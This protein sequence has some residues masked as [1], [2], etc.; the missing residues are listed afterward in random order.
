MDSAEVKPIA[1][2]CTFFGNRRVATTT[3]QG[4]I[5]PVKK[6]INDT[7]KA[8]RRKPGTSQKTSSRNMEMRRYIAIDKLSPS[9]GDTNPNTNLPTVMPSQKPVSAIPEANA[10]PWRTVF[11]KT[12]I[13]P[14]IPTSI[15]P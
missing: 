12:T 15:P 10:L 5:V 6:P 11:M 8:E 4:K 7:A 14:P 1:A 3:T 2:T 9:R 13:Q